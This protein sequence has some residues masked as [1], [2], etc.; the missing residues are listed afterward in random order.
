[1]ARSASEAL[2][3]GRVTPG[4][5]QG[6][7][8]AFPRVQ[9][10]KVTSA[11]SLWPKLQKVG[12]PVAKEI[13]MTGGGGHRTP[14]PSSCAPGGGHRPAGAVALAL[15]G[16]SELGEDALPGPACPPDPTEVTW[17]P[18][19]QGDTRTGCP[20]QMGMECPPVSWE[21]PVGPGHEDN[22][23][24]ADLVSGFLTL[25]EVKE[26]NFLIPRQAT[27]LREKAGEAKCRSA[28]QNKTSQRPCHPLASGCDWPAG[29][30]SGGLPRLLSFFNG[31]D[32]HVT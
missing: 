6:P 10:H 13:R 8:S 18:L 24:T 22:G 16:P 3:L 11:C 9:G 25:T 15:H 27:F 7:H 4:W 21:V 19:V 20:V 14:P 17:T 31:G 32:T 23:E 28:P 2:P 5:S 29:P 26:L 12:Q 30:L 1:M